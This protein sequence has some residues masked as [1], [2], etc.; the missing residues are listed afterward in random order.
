VV[1]HRTVGAHHGLAHGTVG[2]LVRNV[3]AAG[4][5]GVV[6]WLA[7]HHLGPRGVLESIA[8]VVVGTVVG[9]ALYLLV[10]MALGGPA[11]VLAVRSLGSAGKGERADR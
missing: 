8:Q 7:I 5:A 9:L 11:P 10:Q 2:A 3:A 6:V 1:L 4:V